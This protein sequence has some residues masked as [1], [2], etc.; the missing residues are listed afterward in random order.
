MRIQQQS[1]LVADTGLDSHSDVRLQTPPRIPDDL[2]DQQQ[3]VQQQQQPDN[4]SAVK[5]DVDEDSDY[6][7]RK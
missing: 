3:D 2:V 1:D 5:H 6:E 7:E 4:L